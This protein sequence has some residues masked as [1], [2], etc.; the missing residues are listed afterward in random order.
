[1][2]NEMAYLLGMICGNG[3]IKRGSSETIFSIEIPHKKLSTE[4][5]HDIKLYVKASI[6]DI[7]NIIEPLAGTGL[8]SIQPESA[9][10]LSFVKPNTDYITREILQYTGMAASHNNVK[11]HEKI[12]AFSKDEKRQFLKGFADVTGYIR[13]SNYFF[14]RYMHRVYLEIP[15]NWELVTDISNLLK[16]LDIPVQSIDWAHPNMRD[17]QL[18][19]Y[20]KGNHSFWKKEHQIKIFANEF[21]SIGFAVLHK[22]QSLEMFSDEL[23]AGLKA[24][25]VNASDKTHIFYWQQ[26]GKLKMKPLHPCEDDEFIHAKIRG[27]HFN[28]WKEIAKELGYGE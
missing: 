10:I 18:K 1:M 16:D 5:H 22:Q 24:Q 23:I 12:F 19:K 27:T 11:L 7:R 28:S 6:T 2:N 15:H 4:E 14:D 26:H 25:G 17:P 20:N 8:S 3:E 9:T 13:R 21:L